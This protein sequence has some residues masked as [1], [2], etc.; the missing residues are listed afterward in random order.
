MTDK[1]TDE[2]AIDA[3]K[4]HVLNLKLLDD[5]APE[6]PSGLIFE[7]IDHIAARLSPPKA[8]EAEDD[9]FGCPTGFSEWYSRHFAGQHVNVGRSFDCEAAWRHAIARTAQKPI[10]Q[11]AALNEPP[12][13]AGQ[14]P[15]QEAAARARYTQWADE[16]GIHSNRFPAWS[17]L[18]DAKRREWLD[19]VVQAD[20]GNARVDR[21]IGRLMHADPTHQDC[22]DAA[23]MIREFCTQQAVSGPVAEPVAVVGDMYT[24]N[25]IGSGPIA[26][27]IERHKIKPGT[28]LYAAPPAQQEG[29]LTAVEISVIEQLIA[30]GAAALLLADNTVDN[31]D[32]L[33]IDREDFDAVSKCL[34][35]LDE[36]PDDQPGY[37]MHAAGKAQWALRRVPASPGAQGGEL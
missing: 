32:S 14:L 20:T 30:L 4:T 35:V 24:I 23:A 7:A 13:I 27:L 29:A 8:E 17:E 21:M 31:G 36:L 33:E 6:E 22:S 10:A 3:L 19:G 26:P 2:R 1:M 37:T 11:E 18:P 9:E 16:Q 15:A 12:G 28:L 5:D 34:D 25:W